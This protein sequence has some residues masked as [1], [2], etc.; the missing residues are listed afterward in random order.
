MFKMLISTI[1]DMDE[2]MIQ[3][4]TESRSGTNQRQNEADPHSVSDATAN[5]Y[6]NIGS[7]F[8]PTALDK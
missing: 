1:S 4:N 3:K 5:F 2:R 7:F 6:K 8:N